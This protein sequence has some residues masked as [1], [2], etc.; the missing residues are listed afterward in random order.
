MNNT[1]PSIGKLMQYEHFSCY[2]A[3]KYGLVEAIVI[4][5]ISNAINSHQVEVKRVDGLIYAKLTID[6]LS[7]WMDYLS[8]HQI[9]RVVDKLVKAGVVKKLFLNDSKMDRSA[10]LAISEEL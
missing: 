10:W 7:S 2:L 5:N 6:T 9:R 8:S 3:G 1:S 4:S